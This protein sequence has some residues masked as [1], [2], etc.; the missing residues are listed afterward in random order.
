[1]TKLEL[2]GHSNRKRKALNRWLDVIADYKN[3]I[4]AEDIAEKHKKTRAWVYW[5]LRKYRNNQI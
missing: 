5:V 3:G 2:Q 4:S 1:M